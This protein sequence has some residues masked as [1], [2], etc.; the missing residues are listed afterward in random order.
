VAAR[1]LRA[2]LQA[3]RLDLQAIGVPRDGLRAAMIAKRQGEDGKAG[4]A[5]REE[6]VERV[7]GQIKDVRGARRFLRRGCAC[8]AEWR[9][10]RGTHN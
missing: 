10:L 5:M 1:R 6:T 7:F 4:Y 3:G 9:L 2:E 8:Q